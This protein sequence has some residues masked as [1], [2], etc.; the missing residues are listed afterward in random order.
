LFSTV[1]PVIQ[2][3]RLICS[4]QMH[5]GAIDSVGIGP[6]SFRRGDAKLGWPPGWPMS[7]RWLQMCF[8]SQTT[9][10]PVPSYHSNMRKGFS[11]TC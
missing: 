5:S 10:P 8:A 7:Q 11:T 4:A 1:V 3:S 2:R 9:L 6:A